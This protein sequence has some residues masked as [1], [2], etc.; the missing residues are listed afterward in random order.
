MSP[1]KEK[2]ALPHAPLLSKLS[3]TEY[4]WRLHIQAQWRG[5]ANRLFTEYKRSGNPEHLIAHRV[6]CAAMKRPRQRKAPR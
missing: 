1:F 5:E 4:H 2:G 3:L 6:H